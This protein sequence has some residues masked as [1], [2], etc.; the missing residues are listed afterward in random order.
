MNNVVYHG[1]PDNL[2]IITPHK[3][4]HGKTCIYATKKFYY[5]FFITN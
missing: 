1:S 5:I 4:T 3:S 2:D